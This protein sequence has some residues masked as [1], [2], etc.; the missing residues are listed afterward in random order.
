M[1]RLDPGQGWTQTG[2]RTFASDCVPRKISRRCPFVS[3]TRN[4]TRRC[5]NSYANGFVASLLLRKLHPCY[6]GKKINILLNPLLFF[7]KIYFCKI[8]V[9][10]YVLNHHPFIVLLRDKIIDLAE[11]YNIYSYFSKIPLIFYVETC[12][13]P[14]NRPT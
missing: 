12:F 2:L 6:T 8:C 11:Y 7:L 4:E 5:R 9:K 1:W 3:F 13:N 14:E 10:S